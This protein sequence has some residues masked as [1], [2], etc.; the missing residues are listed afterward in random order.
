MADFHFVTTTS[1][2]GSHV[3][4][5]IAPANHLAGDERER[6]RWLARTS[7]VRSFDESQ[8]LQVARALQQEAL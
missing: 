8:M 6:M 3:R 2:S 4:T 5:I 1:S 7:D